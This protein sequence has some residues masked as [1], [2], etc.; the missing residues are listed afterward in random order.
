M[1]HLA[2]R[3]GAFRHVVFSLMVLAAP[4]LRAEVVTQRATRYDQIPLAFERSGE[5]EF[6]VRSPGSDLRISASEIG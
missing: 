2:P 6:R 5:Q 4:G 3:F 1:Y